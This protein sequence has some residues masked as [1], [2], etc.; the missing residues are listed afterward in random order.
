MHLVGA[1]LP[2][3]RNR[4]QPR[5]TS[6]P[7]ASPLAL[8]DRLAASAA[9]RR[10]R[11]AVVLGGADHWPR[12]HSLDHTV[13]W[14][15]RPAMLSAS[16]GMTWASRCRASDEATSRRDARP[17]RLV[18]EHPH[19][20]AWSPRRST[21]HRGPSRTS[22]T[23]PEPYVVRLTMPLV[24]RLFRAEAASRARSTCEACGRSTT[25]SAWPAAPS[26]PPPQLLDNIPSDEAGAEPCRSSRHAEE[27]SRCRAR[28]PG[29]S[30]PRRARRGHRQ[31]RGGGPGS[32]RTASRSCSGRGRNA[33][34]WGGGRNV[35]RGRPAWA[36]VERRG[37]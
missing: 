23:V 16:S 21:R 31:R 32:R 6:A 4:H 27:A 14:R 36:T 25:T 26:P 7:V 3:R 1:R 11:R 24:P 19:P 30:G 5:V 37:S 12:S 18:A 22:A 17:G 10:A 34:G 35:R 2:F 20:T 8:E 13:P 28:A 15:A 9:A 29:T 33:R